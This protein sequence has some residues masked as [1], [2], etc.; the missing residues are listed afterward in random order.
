[1]KPDPSKKKVVVSL[2]DFPTLSEFFAAY[3]HQDFID[4]YGSAAGAAKQYLKDATLEEC[5]SLRSDWKRFRTKLSGRPISEVQ[6]AVR[7]LG[8]A[9][10]PNSNSALADVDAALKN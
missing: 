7:K 9:W 6:A 2:E 5:V 3:L 1:M 10:L 8:A 4:E